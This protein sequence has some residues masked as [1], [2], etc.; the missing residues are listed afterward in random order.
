MKEQGL[1]SAVA[2]PEGEKSMVEFQ[3]KFT[4]MCEGC[5]CPEL[6]IVTRKLF[7]D[8]EVADVA[9]DVVCYKE[10]QCKK[11]IEH[12]KGGAQNAGD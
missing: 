5:P 12:L 1:M 10:Q 11:L 4:G 6:S 2:L 7:A 9:F 3:I 8:Q